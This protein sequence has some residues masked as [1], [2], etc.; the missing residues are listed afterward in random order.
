MKPHYRSFSQLA[1]ANVA[2]IGAGGFIGSHLIDSLLSNK[3]HVLALGRNLPG[4]ISSEAQ[5][6]T[7]LTMKSVDMTDS[8]KLQTCLSKID[9]VYHL[10]SSCLPK[11]SNVS[12]QLDV[13]TNLIGSLNILQ[14]CIKNNIKKLIF[15][16]S[17]GTVYGIPRNFP[18]GENHPTNPL[19]SYGVNKLAIEKYIYMYRELYGLDSTVLR[20]AN[21]YGEGQRLKAS[22]GV[23]PIFLNLALNSK[24]L[25][26]WG[27][28]S[29]VRDF[30]YISDVVEAILLSSTCNSAEHV[31]NIGSGTGCSLLSLVSMI[32]KIVGKKVNVHFKESRGFDVPKNV[33]C[34]DKAKQYLN[35]EPSISLEVGV[36]RLYRYLVRSSD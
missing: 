8:L 16:S 5:L 23:V 6:N 15:I 4:L 12:P 14:S 19:C 29:A 20:L 9:I 3:C 24:T 1:G 35:W 11:S 13:S 7:N 22:Q 28:G 32:E 18:I 17:G 27:D 25:E 36:S 21:P 26:I 33:L 30:I 34:I 2:V 10:A 31:F